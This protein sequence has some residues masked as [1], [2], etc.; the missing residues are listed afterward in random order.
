MGVHRIDMYPIGVH[1][2]GAYPMGLDYWYVF[3]GGTSD[4]ACILWA[5]ISGRVSYGLIAPKLQPSLRHDSNLSASSS[6]PL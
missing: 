6:P 1:S 5:G 2:I 4:G 3:Q